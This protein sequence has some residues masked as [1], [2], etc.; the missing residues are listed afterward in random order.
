MTDQELKAKGSGMSQILVDADTPASMVAVARLS[1]EEEDVFLFRTRHGE[2]M[3]DASTIP[4]VLRLLDSVLLGQVR[5]V[6]L[7]AQE[8]VSAGQPEAGTDS[9]WVQGRRGEGAAPAWLSARPGEVWALMVLGMP[10]VVHA[11]VGPDRRF[12]FVPPHGT[13]LDGL[14]F[15]SRSIV[16]GEKVQ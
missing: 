10:E 8:L 3:I 2:V 7:A 15:T 6:A 5:S 11:L 14:P 13:T 4:E 16:K 1:S 9:T 12:M